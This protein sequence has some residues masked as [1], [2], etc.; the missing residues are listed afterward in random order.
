MTPAELH[1]P[2]A[3]LYSQDFVAWVEQTV[4][5]LRSQ[6]FDNIDWENVIEEI[7]DMSRRERRRLES[8]LIVILVHLLKWQ[9]QPEARSGSWK[10]SLREHRRRVN[11]DL[12][13]S[14]SLRPYLQDSLADSYGNAREQAADET[15][16]AIA[17]FPEHNLYSVEE[18]LNPQ[19]LPD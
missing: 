11:R 19:F 14:P 10:G 13:D 15:G 6:D 8:N 1:P 16:L 9:Y 5:Q 12:D 2:Q 18:I 17:T 3:S 7:A 4:A